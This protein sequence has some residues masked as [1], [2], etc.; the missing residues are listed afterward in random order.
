EVYHRLAY[1]KLIENEDD[2]NEIDKA[3]SFIDENASFFL[4]LC[5]NQKIGQWIDHHVFYLNKNH[6]FCYINDDKKQL[7]NILSEIFDLLN[8]IFDDLQMNII[9][10]KCFINIDEIMKLTEKYNFSYLYDVCDDFKSYML[11]FDDIEG[12]IRLFQT[13][14]IQF[15]QLNDSVNNNFFKGREIKNDATYD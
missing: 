3:F 13:I 15:E 9:S 6:D 10:E 2:I 5:K 11:Y 14:A 1:L 7:Q 8:D 4:E 12:I